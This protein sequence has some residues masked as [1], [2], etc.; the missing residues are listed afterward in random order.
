[1]DARF[2]AFVGV[3]ALLTVT[4]G[5]DMALVTK[6][7]LGGGRRAAFLATLGITVGTLLWAAASGLG[8][9]ALLNASATAFTA[10]KLAGAAYLILIGVQTVWQSRGGAAG[11]AAATANRRLGDGR[12]F[13][14]GL[15][16]N[17][18]NPKVGVFYTSFLPQFIE[19]GDPVFVRSLLLAL[20]HLTIGVAWL[21]V[22]AAAVTRAGDVL[23]RPRVK[24]TLDRVTG[25]V[26]V[27]LGVR[28]AVE[29]R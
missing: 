22:Y 19:P 8:L 14:Q 6:H 16:T 21:T 29:E 11:T 23:R 1:M 13:R 15:L 4:P 2:L 26:L 12:A 9:A 3:A 17:L 28:L 24:R 27:G 5:A 18:L 20:V 7:A 25:A 10:L